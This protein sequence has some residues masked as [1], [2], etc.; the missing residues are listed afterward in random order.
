VTTIAAVQGDGW[1]VVGYDSRVTEESRVF[2]LPSHNGKVI[3]NG[4]Y[5][6]GA[7]GDLRAVNLVAHTFR[8]PTPPVG[9]D[10]SELDRFVATKLVPAL[11]S[12]FEDA[13]YGEKGEQDSTIIAVVSGTIYEIGSNYEWCHDSHGL[14][15]L[16]SG[17]AFAL[18]ALHSSIG[19][20]RVTI[21]QA[22]SAV[23]SAVSI[24]ARLDSNTGGPIHTTS[25]TGQKRSSV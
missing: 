3:R 17:G 22:R 16:G 8:P 24:A 18:G 6:I 15:G 11:K 7:A 12:C 25:Q 1:A 2:T 10:L 19:G 21:Q 23:R 5:V 9:A 13:N 14:H 20:R 4:P